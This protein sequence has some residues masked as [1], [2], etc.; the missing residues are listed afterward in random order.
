MRLDF[1]EATAPPAE[2]GDPNDGPRIITVDHEVDHDAPA[3][4]QL[5][6]SLPFT[7]KL[8]R[9]EMQLRKAVKVRADAYLR[10]APQLGRQLIEPEAA[11]R[12]AGNVVLLAESK[13]TGDPEGSIRIE[14]NFDSRTEFEAL[15]PLPPQFEGKTMAQVSRLGI[16]TGPG[17][18]LV[19]QALFKAL[20]RFCLATQIDYMMVAAR[21]PVDRDFLKLGFTEAF[22][23]PTL[24]HYPKQGRKMLRLFAF[25]VAAGERMWQQG[26]HPLYRFMIVDFH[27]D[28][29]IFSSVRGMWGKP[30]RAA[31]GRGTP[32]DPLAPPPLNLDLPLV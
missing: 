29:E 9:T 27:P 1:R 26:A 28:I 32:S 16:R 17:G 25:D 13:E 23:S 3:Q 15:L 20:Y 6:V 30:R 31:T 18:T 14:T 7:V 22:T 24:L 4:R 12:A 21:T 11:D 2:G 19:K 8:V 5:G 10:H